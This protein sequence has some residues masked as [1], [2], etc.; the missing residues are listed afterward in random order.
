MGQSPAELLKT[1]PCTLRLA[2]HPIATSVLQ[3]DRQNARPRPEGAEIYRGV[4]APRRKAVN[5]PSK[6][7][8]LEMPAVSPA[9]TVPRCA[10]GAR[11]HFCSFCSLWRCLGLLA[12]IRASRDQVISALRS[13]AAVDFWGPWAVA[14]VPG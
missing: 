5:E 3:V 11:C 6:L 10:S 7:E 1:V 8:D 13:R 2:W 9:G 14:C 4:Q 12:G